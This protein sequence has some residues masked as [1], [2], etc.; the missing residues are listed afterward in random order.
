MSRLLLTFCQAELVS[1]VSCLWNSLHMS[2]LHGFYSYGC[3]FKNDCHK[4]NF[5]TLLLKFENTM[6]FL[7]SHEFNFFVGLLFVFAVI[8]YCYVQIVVGT[9]SKDATYHSP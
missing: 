5:F 7:Y 8:S 6:N 3:H 2:A 9:P 4:Y 1:P